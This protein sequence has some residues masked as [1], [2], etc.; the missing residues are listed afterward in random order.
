[1]IRKVL[2]EQK[3]G[4]QQK[5]NTIKSEIYSRI[6]RGSPKA[7]TFGSEPIRGRRLRIGSLQKVHDFIVHWHILKNIGFKN[8]IFWQDIKIN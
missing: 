4:V 1:M 5:N 2:P 7:C 8:H 3:K 6:D